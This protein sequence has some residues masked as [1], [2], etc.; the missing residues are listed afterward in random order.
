MSRQ[1]RLFLLVIA[2][3]AAVFLLYFVRDVLT[4]FVLA[5]ILAYFANPLVVTFVQRDVP[6]SAAIFIVYAVFGVGLALVIYWILPTLVRE[7]NGLLI[8]LPA[9]AG[10]MELTLTRW[11]NNLVHLP[12]SAWVQL[13]ATNALHRGEL[14]LQ[15]YS[16]RVLETLISYVPKAFNLIIA[17]F[18]AYYILRDMNVLYRAAILLVPRSRREDCE[19]V[20]HDLNK[21][22]SGFVRGQLIVSAFVGIMAAIFLAVL[23]VEYPLLI[24]VFIGAFDI[25]PYFGPV[26]G[27]VPAVA[28]GLIKSPATAMWVVVMLVVVNQIEGAILQ[29]RIVGGRVGLHPLTVIFAVLAGGELLGIWGMLL[30]VPAAAAIK[31]IGVFTLDKLISPGER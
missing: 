25:I 26:I 30:A 21:A 22:I 16:V 8:T 15:S 23:G 20:L 1:T 7:L 13:F 14:L 24:G 2:A 19:R 11:M 10:E 31:V 4:P 5:A 27:G 6:R 29:P 3:G 28:L 9:A 12:G 17:P 18:L